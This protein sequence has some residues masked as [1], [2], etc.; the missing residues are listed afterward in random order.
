MYRADEVETHLTADS[1]LDRLDRRKEGKRAK[2]NS[3]CMD[4]KVWR[5]YTVCR[6][7]QKKKDAIMKQTPKKK[8]S[9]V[10]PP[11]WLIAAPKKDIDGRSGHWRNIIQ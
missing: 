11:T 10:V 5:F 3:V 2:P 1:F 7:Q 8:D 4:S 6:N 9:D